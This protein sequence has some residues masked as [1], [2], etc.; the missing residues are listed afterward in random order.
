[1]RL[2]HP[3]PARSVLAALLLSLMARDSDFTPL[4]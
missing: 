4:P 2:A 3:F 1:M